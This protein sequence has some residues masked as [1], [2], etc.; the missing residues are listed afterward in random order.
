VY[1]GKLY[2]CT[3]SVCTKYIFGGSQ[4]IA[5]KKQ[6]VVY[7]YHTDHL[8]SSSVI[9]DSAGTKIEEIYYYPYGGTRINS[10]TVN[11]KHK[12][13][14]QE[15]DA[16]TGLYYYGAR[17]YDPI[18]G[19]FISADTIVQ[20][21][22]DPQS[23]NRYSYCINNP[24]KY[25]DPTGHGWWDVVINAAVG[26][27][28][29]AIAAGIASDWNGDAMLKG[30]GVGAV[31][32]MVGGAVGGAVSG[33]MTGAGY[34][35]AVSSVVGGMAGGAAAG[36]TASAM[37]GGNVWQGAM[38]GAI[39]GAAFGAIGAYYGDS[40]WGWDRVV[41]SGLAGGGVNELAGGRFMDGFMFAAVPV[42]ARALYNDWVN[43]DSTWGS[44]G[45]VV[46]KKYLDPP[47]RG[48]NNVGTQ[49]EPLNP[50][51]WFNE[52]GRV[53]R[54]ANRIPG[55]NAVGGLHDVFQITID[56]YLGNFARNV[57]N[58][59]GMLPAAAITYSALVTDY[60]GIV[61]YQTVLMRDERR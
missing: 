20:N 61:N 58:V 16:E 39:G 26:A 33:A 55:I 57:F 7:Y 52:G 11:V 13:T 8:G 51:G 32:G 40:Y 30:A 17:Y 1:I 49:G 53:S 41:V 2:E 24:L 35:T 12:F 27:V 23:L 50:N 42:A 31:A 9:T 6:G 3:S 19:R 5:T 18:L 34:S 25:T 48:A 56:R 28:V 4:K 60:S 46:E 15:E 45:D 22:F 29:G 10:G 54:F 14:G 37:Y 43:Y 21:P 59:P 44:G 47:V 38:Y 36:A